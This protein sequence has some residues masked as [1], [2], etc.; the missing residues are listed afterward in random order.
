V[1][2]ATAALQEL[3]MARNSLVA[4]SCIIKTRNQQ[5]LEL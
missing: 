3:K 1:T 5:Q 2:E 4:F